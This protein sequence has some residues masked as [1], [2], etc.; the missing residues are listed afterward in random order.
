MTMNISPIKISPVFNFREG[1]GVTLTDRRP[2]AHSGPRGRWLAVQLAGVDP[3]GPL[4]PRTEKT[5]GMPLAVMCCEQRAQG[6]YWVQ[7]EL[8]AREAVGC[9]M[10][11]QNCEP[12]VW[13][14][15]LVHEYQ[16]AAAPEDREGE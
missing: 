3:P 4:G 13:Y 15:L 7:L 1:E 16:V 11:E 2:E 6:W 9:L 5:P 14:T 8:T 10:L 12:G